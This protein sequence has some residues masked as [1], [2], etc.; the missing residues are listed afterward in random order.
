[1]AQHPDGVDD[2]RMTTVTEPGP[3]AREL[4]RWRGLRRW[5][6]LDLAIRAGTTQRYLSYL[7]QGRS[8]PG[9]TVVLRLAESLG[10]SLRERNTL[11]MS[12]GYAPA[13]AESGLDAPQ[14]RPVRAALRSVLEGHMPYPALI[15]DKH[16]VLVDANAAFTLFFEDCAPE[17][18]RPPVNV[19]RL[20]LH[21]DGLARRVVNLP[22]WGRHVTE[23]LRMRARISPDPELDALVTELEGYLP[24]ADPGPGYLG[25]AVPLRLRADGGELNLITTLMSVATATDISLAELHLEAFLPADEATAEILRARAEHGKRLP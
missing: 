8:Q 14:L 3:F 25:F 24:P 21:P 9:R 1:M 22:E 2:G 7:E 4:R 12:A 20:A 15:V 5:S 13:F 23:A 10:L 11:L 18:L 16:S 6:Q 17:L 19:R